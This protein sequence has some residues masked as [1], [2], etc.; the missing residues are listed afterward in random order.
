MPRPRFQRAIAKY[1]RI[2][3]VQARIKK[4]TTILY[5]SELLSLPLEQIYWFHVLLK[6]HFTVVMMVLTI[7][8]VRWNTCLIMWC[9]NNTNTV[10]THKNESNKTNTNNKYVLFQQ[11]RIISS[12]YITILLRHGPSQHPYNGLKDTTSMVQQHM[13]HIKDQWHILLNRKEI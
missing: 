1:L 4:M 12:C 5:K 8:C 9:L 3:D 2:V 11:P 6:L 13:K 7:G 10:N